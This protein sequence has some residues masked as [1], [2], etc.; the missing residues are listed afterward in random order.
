MVPSA[1][2]DEEIISLH[3]FGVHGVALERYHRERRLKHE[4]VAA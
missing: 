3:R 2:S 4:Y 1:G